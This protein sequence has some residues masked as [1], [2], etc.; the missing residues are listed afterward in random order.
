MEQCVVD[1]GKDQIGRHLPQ[2][3]GVLVLLPVAEPHNDQRV[4][5]DEL[6]KRRSFLC[7]K[8]ILL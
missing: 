4:E 2:Q 1:D 5:A 3:D 7:F 6:G 8:L